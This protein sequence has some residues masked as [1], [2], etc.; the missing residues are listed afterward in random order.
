M[1][2]FPAAIAER[3]VSLL[4]LLA[5]WE[6]AAWFAQSRLFPGPG[7]VLAIVVFGGVS[8]SGSVMPLAGGAHAM[9]FVSAFMRRAWLTNSCSQM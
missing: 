6:G 3:V 4:V 8:K 2:R 9:S 5:A 1:T 7:T